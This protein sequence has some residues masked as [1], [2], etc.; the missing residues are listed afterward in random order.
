MIY[1]DSEV[2]GALSKAD[3]YM[4]WAKRCGNEDGHGLEVPSRW[5]QTLAFA[6][7]AEREKVAE[8][9]KEIERL[10]AALRGSKP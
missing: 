1:T 7:R 6:L 8:A 10:T 2:E 4:E 3:D 5:F 9:R